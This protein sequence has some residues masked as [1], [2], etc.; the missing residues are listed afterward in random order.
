MRKLECD[1]AFNANF[2]SA[3]FASGLGAARLLTDALKPIRRVTLKPRSVRSLR[4]INAAVG[5]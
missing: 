2:G 1:C 3:I 4:V 5:A